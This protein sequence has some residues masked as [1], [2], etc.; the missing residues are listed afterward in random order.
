MDIFYEDLMNK[1]LREELIDLV[2]KNKT[3]YLKGLNSAKRYQIYRQMYHPLAFEKITIDHDD[4]VIKVFDKTKKKE[5]EETEL[6]NKEV[7]SE[8]ENEKDSHNENKSET[9]ETSEDS[10][11]TEELDKIDKL[12]NMLDIIINN[13]SNTNKNIKIIN[14]K[15]HLSMILSIFCWGIFF[16]IDP[17]RLIIDEKKDICII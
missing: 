11:N 6:I 10:Y 14:I 8:E 3:I 12:E 2:K 13:Q 5:E 16:Y 7:S 17:I 15:I 9:T 1:N 4:K